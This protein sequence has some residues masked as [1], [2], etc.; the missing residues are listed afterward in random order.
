MF[1]RDFHMDRDSDSEEQKMVFEY[2]HYILERPGNS[3]LKAKTSML[4]KQFPDWERNL[5][6]AHL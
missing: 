6:E 2:I 4:L 3:A 1:N 5:K